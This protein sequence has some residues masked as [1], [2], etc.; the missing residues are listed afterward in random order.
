MMRV[1]LLSFFCFI[2]LASSAEWH[3]FQ[4]DEFSVHHVCRN[5]AYQTEQGTCVCTRDWQGKYCT[6][7]RVYRFGHYRFVNTRA[8]KENSDW[9]QYYERKRYGCLTHY[10]ANFFEPGVIQGNP[11]LHGGTYRQ[12]GQFVA[13]CRCPPTWTGTCCHLSLI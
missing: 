6:I 12:M 5:Q 3:D 13:W 9:R 1:I 11:C 4:F 10:V 7:P 2:T 8:L